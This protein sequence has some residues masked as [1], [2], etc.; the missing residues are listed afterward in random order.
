MGIIVVSLTFTAYLFGTPP[1]LASL[2]S[3]GRFCTPINCNTFMSV[4][5]CKF[6]NYFTTFYYHSVVLFFLFGTRPYLASL[7]SQ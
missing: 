2:P 6:Y 5:V 3:K 1:Q 7:P 4:L